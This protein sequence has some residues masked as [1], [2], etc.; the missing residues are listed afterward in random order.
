MNINRF[1]LIAALAL[2][3]GG[4]LACTNFAVAQ[5]STNAPARGARR[6][7]PEQ[8]L[9]RMTT[10]LNLTDAQKPK[11]KEWLE[12]TAKKRQELR[13]LSQDERREKSRTLMA[14]QNKKLKEILT[15]DQFEK[16]QKQME[17]RGRRGAAAGAGASQKKSDSN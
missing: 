14:D 1:S 17:R 8:Q 13:G 7:S 6:F 4:S 12:A 11:V 3:L 15:P 16:Y 9:E 10:E 5:E 2:A